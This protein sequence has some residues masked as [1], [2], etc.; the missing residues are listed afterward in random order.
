[1]LRR[2]LGA[3]EEELSEGEAKAE[4]VVEVGNMSM[5]W[6]QSLCA[7]GARLPETFQSSSAVGR[8]AM[9]LVGVRRISCTRV[10][11]TSW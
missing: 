7:S 2:L 4:V 3:E 10:R 11:T 8:F 9:G 1:M 5:L 6:L